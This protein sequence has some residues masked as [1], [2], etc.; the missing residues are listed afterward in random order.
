[1][2]T[3][4]T[5]RTGKPQCFFIDKVWG[6]GAAAAVLL[7]LLLLAKKLNFLG[8]APSNSAAAADE[9]SIQRALWLV[10]MT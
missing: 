10:R 8:L 9:A 1:M 7:L 2:A 6:A 4:R 3:A 5:A